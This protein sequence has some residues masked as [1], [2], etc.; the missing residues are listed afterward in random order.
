MEV[1]SDQ[2]LFDLLNGENGVEGSNLSNITF[3]A[4]KTGFEG[5]VRQDELHP[6]PTVS[7]GC[8]YA[9]KPKCQKRG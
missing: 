9:S 3:N 5:P 1:R 4:F 2:D 7:G 8:A 6:A